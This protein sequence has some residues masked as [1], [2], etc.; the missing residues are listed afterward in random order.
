MCPP[1]LGRERAFQHRTSA[2]LDGRRSGGAGHGGAAHRVFLW[3][4]QSRSGALQSESQLLATVVTEFVNKSTNLWR[5]QPERLTS[6]LQQYGNQ[7]Y[8]SAV[9][10]QEGTVIAHRMPELDRPTLT[11][12]HPIY[13]FGVEVG[14][15]QVVASLRDLL[16]ET[17]WI[18]LAGT[19]LGIALFFRW[20]LSRPAPCGEQRRRSWSAKTLTGSSS[21]YRPI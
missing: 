2:D 18:V 13:D 11:H 16:T 6:L 14:E 15:V 5:F 3:S 19:I 20:D 7:Q 1:R 4:Y 9:I 12:S 8:G 17:A 21:S 10:D